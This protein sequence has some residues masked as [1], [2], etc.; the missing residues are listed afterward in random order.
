MDEAD[1]PISSKAKE[2]LTRKLEELQKKVVKLKAK[3]KAIKIA[4]YSSVIISISLTGVMTT[5]AGFS[6]LPIYIIPILS[7]SSGI[8]TG[9]STKFN[10]EKKKIE[11]N[12]TI[13]KIH[14]IQQKLDY[15]ISC[16]GNFTDEDFKQMM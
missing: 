11:L 6:M 2:Y 3:R 4:Y 13:D 5:L 7:T 14:K 1:S 12:K 15:V 10:L 8:L 9:V 16:N